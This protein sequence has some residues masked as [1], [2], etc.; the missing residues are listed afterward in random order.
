MTLDIYQATKTFPKEE[1][2]G[3]T[4]QIRRA[5]V[6]IIS[7]IAEG[8]GRRSNLETA[9]FFNIAVGSAS[10]LQCQILLARDLKY[11]GDGKAKDFEEEVIEVK[12]M[13]SVFIKKLKERK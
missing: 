7:N 12:K 11:I 6:S 10:E 3:L 2:Y 8:C 1:L 13:T 9:Q 5:S 4:N